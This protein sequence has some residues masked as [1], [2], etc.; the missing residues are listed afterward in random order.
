MPLTWVDW[1]DQD[2]IQ[3]FVKK[4]G[5]NQW[6]SLLVWLDNAIRNGETFGLSEV[7]SAELESQLGKGILSRPEQPF[8]EYEKDSPIWPTQGNPAILISKRPINSDITSRWYIRDAKGNPQN[9]RVRVKANKDHSCRYEVKFETWMNANQIIGQSMEIRVD[10][11]NAAGE[12]SNSITL[13]N[14][15]E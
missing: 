3:I 5:E 14:P 4:T 8:L 15:G 7:M 12:S 11:G 1:R 13:T 2:M 6:K 9:Q 10:W